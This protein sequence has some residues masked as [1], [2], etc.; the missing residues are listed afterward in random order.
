MYACRN[1]SVTM[2]VGSFKQRQTG[3]QIETNL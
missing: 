2:Y 3:W 1:K